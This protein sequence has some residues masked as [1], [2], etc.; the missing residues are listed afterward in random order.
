[1]MKPWHDKFLKKGDAVRDNG[2]EL[3]RG[4]V[5]RLLP[6]GAEILWDQG[7]RSTLGFHWINKVV[8]DTD[9]AAHPVVECPIDI[10][11]LGG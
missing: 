5:E 7:R 1:M 10:P 4:I 3:G 8:S 2:G 9:R 6:Y 11:D